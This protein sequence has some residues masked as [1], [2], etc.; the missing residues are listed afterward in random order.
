MASRLARHPLNTTTDG[1]DTLVTRGCLPSQ[2]MTE[3]A[4]MMMV[5]AVRLG[6]SHGLRCHECDKGECK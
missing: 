5:M 2:E 6:G 1:D 4:M 3:V